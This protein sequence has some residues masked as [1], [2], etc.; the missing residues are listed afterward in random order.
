MQIPLYY[1]TDVDEVYKYVCGFSPKYFDEYFTKQEFATGYFGLFGIP[2]DIV[3]RDAIESDEYF[4]YPL[5]VCFQPIQDIIQQYDIPDDV[6][7][8]IHNKKVKIIVVCPF[9]GWDWQWWRNLVAP[10]C[11]RY[12][13]GLS[14]FV[15][16][17]ANSLKDKKIRCVYNSFWERQTKHE[18]LSWLNDK[19]SIEVATRR[20]KKHKFICLNRRPHAGRIAATT[21]LYDYKDQGLLSL[22]INGQMHGSYLSDQLRLFRDTYP[23]I[24]AQF[25]KKNIKS[26]MPLKIDDGVDP[27]VENPVHDLA[28]DKFYDSYL[29]ICP[30]TFQYKRA[31]RVFFSEKIFKPIMYMQPFTLIGEP[32]GLRT[33]REMGYETFGDIIDESYDEIDDNQE[34]ITAAVN[35]SIKFFNRPVEEIENDMSVIAWKLSHNISH[36]QYRSFMMDLNLKKELSE[37]LYG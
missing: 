36:L 25:N 8:K 23:R 18:D 2:F 1:R 13:I 16:V 34:R 33:L 37:H 22:G 4:Y 5:I 24:F 32:Y 10:I 3:F 14:D 29:H 35:A 17:N 30:E 19:G 11:T 7:K 28:V 9:E 21:L 20:R 12:G 15:F 27:E 6:L 31:G 26:Q